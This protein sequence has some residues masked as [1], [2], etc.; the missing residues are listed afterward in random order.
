M[1]YAQT[2]KDVRMDVARFAVAMENKLRTHDGD[3]G[4]RGW[5]D[6][7]LEWLAWRIQQEVTE[8]YGQMRCYTG[9]DP[10][11]EAVDIANF[12]MMFFVNACGKSRSPVCRRCGSAFSDVDRMDPYGDWCGC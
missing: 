5:E 2:I 10:A 6:S 11:E 3:R 4:E 9:N 8:L 12:A 1:E 7:G